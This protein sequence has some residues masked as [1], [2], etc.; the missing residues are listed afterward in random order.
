M[1]YN[2]AVQWQSQ[3]FRGGAKK[4]MV[5]GRRGQKGVA[6]MRGT[7]KSAEPEGQQWS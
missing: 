4:N 3:I 1:A 2:G 6:R 5:R 7:K